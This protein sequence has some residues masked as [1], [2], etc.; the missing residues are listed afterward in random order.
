MA[1]IIAYCNGH[2]PIVFLGMGI[3]RIQNFLDILL[4]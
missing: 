1:A 2:C 3:S 4:A